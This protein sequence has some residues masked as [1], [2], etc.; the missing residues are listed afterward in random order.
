MIAGGELV[1]SHGAVAG[2]EA[3]E[4]GLKR[5]GAAKA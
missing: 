1:E 2:G 5:L 3:G 4:K